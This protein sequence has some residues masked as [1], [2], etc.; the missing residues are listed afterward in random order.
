MQ[1]FN[2]S[3]VFGL[4]P[5]S[6]VLIIRGSWS[7]SITTGRKLLRLQERERIDSNADSRPLAKQRL[8]LRQLPSTPHHEIIQVSLVLLR[9]VLP[10]LFPLFLPMNFVHSCALTKCGSYNELDWSIPLQWMRVLPVRMILI[11]KTVNRK[12]RAAATVA[13]QVSTCHLWL[14]TLGRLQYFMSYWCFTDT[15]TS[16][17]NIFF[18]RF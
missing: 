1:W 10:F 16:Y 6:C 4:F 8:A 15:C 13:Q 5:K 14:I 7:L 12:S 18:N 2:G 17:L 3:H 11:V 9:N